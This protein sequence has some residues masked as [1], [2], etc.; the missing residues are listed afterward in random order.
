MWKYNKLKMTEKQRNIR[1][2]FLE[3]LL[4]GLLAGGAAAIAFYFVQN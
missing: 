4:I 1:K 3:G 2:C